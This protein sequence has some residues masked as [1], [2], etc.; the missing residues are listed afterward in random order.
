MTEKPILFSAPMV[1]AIL[2]GSKTQTRRIIKLCGQRPDYIGPSGCESDPTCWGWPDDEHG[3]YT[4]IIRD[5]DDPNQRI[6]WTE[7]NVAH[8]V[9]DTLYVCE[10]HYRFGYWVA[11]GKTKTGAVKWRFVGCDDDATFVQPMVFRV[12]RDKENPD[13]PQWYRRLG[14]FMFARH[15]RIHLRVTGVKVER[16]QDISEADA[17]AEGVLLLGKYPHF[18]HRFVFGAIWNSLHSPDAWGENPWVAACTFERVR[19]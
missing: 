14:R 9:G 10:T 8:Q 5:K 2:D 19:P 13:L 15:A 16:L 17:V 18:T 12:S 11:N 3:G 6:A 1:R 7:A 4:T